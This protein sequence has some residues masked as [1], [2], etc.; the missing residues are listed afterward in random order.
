MPVRLKI[1]KINIDV[2]LDHLGL[3]SNGEL[4]VPKDFL[5]AGWYKLG[6]RPGDIG[7]AVID[8]HIGSRKIVGVFDNLHKLTIGDIVSVETDQG[9]TLDFVI[10]ETR[11]Y[12]PDAHVPEIFNKTDG[13]L[14]NI[15]TCYGTWDRSERTFTERL[16]IFTELKERS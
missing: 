14:L 2:T 3:T 5:K 7:S 4:D 8:G 9:T 15:I 11:T 16:V 10:K 1:P 13:R 12:D 6:P